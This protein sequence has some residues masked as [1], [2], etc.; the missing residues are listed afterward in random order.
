MVDM[1]INP[2]D[3]DAVLKEVWNTEN[4]DAKTEFF[5][6]DNMDTFNRLDTM[7][8]IFGSS[9]LADHTNRA[10]IKLKSFKRKSMD[11][12]VNVVR[13]KREDLMQKGGSF[14]KNMTG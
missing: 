9:L 4:I 12:F 13:A 14:F 10:K 2:L 5:N 6:S 3:E 7:S 8:D 11:E 1:E